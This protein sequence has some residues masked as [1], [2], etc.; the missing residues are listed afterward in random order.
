M[1]NL[2]RIG[3][4]AGRPAGRFERRGADVLAVERVGA[5]A[6]AGHDADVDA[7]LVRGVGAEVAGLLHRHLAVA[8]QQ[9]DDD[10]LVLVVAG[11]HAQALAQDVDDPRVDQLADRAR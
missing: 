2:T 3:L 1:A 6:L 11:D 9:V 5:V 10:V 8:R 4:R 7:G